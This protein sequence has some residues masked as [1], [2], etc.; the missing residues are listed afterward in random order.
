MNL[1]YEKLNLVYT[2]TDADEQIAYA[3]EHDTLVPTYNQWIDEYD[4][5]VAEIKSLR[6]QLQ[7][8]R[9]D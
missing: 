1:L 9:D 4:A 2:T 6:E 8:M 3:M 7:G 5:S